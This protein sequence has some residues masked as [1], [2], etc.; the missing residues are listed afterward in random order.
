MEVVDDHAMIDHGNFQTPNKN[1]LDSNHQTSLGPFLSF[2]V[3]I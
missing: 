1:G 2:L 3:Q